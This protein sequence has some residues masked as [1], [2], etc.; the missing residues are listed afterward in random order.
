[1]RGPQLLGAQ[2]ARALELRIRVAEQPFELTGDPRPLVD[3]VRDRRDRNL[4]DTLLRPQA[5]PHLARDGAVQLGDAVR[6]LRG[7]ERERREPES[8]LVGL[9]LAERGELVP[10]EA[11]P[12]DETLEVAAHELRVED[13]VARRHRRV[14]REH[15]RG[16]QPLERF[17]GR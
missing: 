16:A 7:A 2:F 13:L 3:A 12:L 8:R 4:V 9:D 5:V 10:A 14:C 15:R 1:M 6:V 11:A 17:L